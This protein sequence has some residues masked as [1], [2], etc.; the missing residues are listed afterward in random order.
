M[1]KSVRAIIITK[2]NKLLLMKRTKPDGSYL[3]KNKPRPL[4]MEV[5]LAISKK[6]ELITAHKANEYVTIHDLTKFENFFINM[7]RFNQQKE[8]E[9]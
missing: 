2:D 9:Y 5:K 8:K 7:K 3:T 1:R 4:H 6:W